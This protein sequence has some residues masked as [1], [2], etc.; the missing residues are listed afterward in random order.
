MNSPQQRTQDD[1]LQTIAITLHY[2]DL[3][4]DPERN[5]LSC[6]CGADLSDLDNPEEH[7]AAAIITA[8]SIYLGTEW[9]VMNSLNGNQLG[10]SSTKEADRDEMLN[11]IAQSKGMPGYDFALASRIAWPWTQ[12]PQ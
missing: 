11:Q 5:T 8:L 10:P 12:A 1:A 6:I 9:A 3:G 7:Q 2:H 4:V